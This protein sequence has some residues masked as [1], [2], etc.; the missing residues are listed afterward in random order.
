MLGQYY[1]PCATI[2]ESLKISSQNKFGITGK[3]G[4]RIS[5]RHDDRIL[6]NV[7]LKLEG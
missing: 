7:V 4:L 3:R 1:N 5:Q 2:V 6:K